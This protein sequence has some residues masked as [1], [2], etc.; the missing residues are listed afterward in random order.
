MKKLLASIL[1]IIICSYA[2]T[3]NKTFQSID[4][5]AYV[6]ALGIDTSD[7]NNLIVSFQIAIP[8]QAEGL[9]SRWEYT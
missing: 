1:I 9:T 6:I 8:S 3:V 2:F 5:L 4:D 7:S